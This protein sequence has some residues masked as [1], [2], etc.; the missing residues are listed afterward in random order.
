[1]DRLGGRL[2]KNLAG[3]FAKWLRPPVV[4]AHLPDDT[5]VEK[6][7]HTGLAHSKITTTR[8]FHGCRLR[9]F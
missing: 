2:Q 5:A 9:K 1:M 4:D 6:Q 3:L 8:I 7:L